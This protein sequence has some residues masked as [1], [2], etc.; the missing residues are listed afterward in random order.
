MGISDYFFLAAFFFTDDFFAAFFF[1][2]FFA[3][4]F[5]VATF[6]VA[7]FFRFL[8]VAPGKP[9]SSSTATSF[10]GAINR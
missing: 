3:V 6:F 7:T 4:T 10:L 9:F 2:G 8:A 5:F 1:V